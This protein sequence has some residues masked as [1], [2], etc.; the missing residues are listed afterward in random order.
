MDI[1][2]EQDL[3]H[4]ESLRTASFG[5]DAVDHS[6]FSRIDDEL[7]LEPPMWSMGIWMIRNAQT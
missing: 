6:L 1:K 5:N 2:L 7:W 4:L 3:S